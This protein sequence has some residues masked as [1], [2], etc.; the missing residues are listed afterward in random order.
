MVNGIELRYKG[1]SGIRLPELQMFQLCSKAGRY[2]PFLAIQ[3]CVRKPCG[4]MSFQISELLKSLQRLM[5][6]LRLN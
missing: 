4:V 3:P 5:E 1:D 6:D 2:V